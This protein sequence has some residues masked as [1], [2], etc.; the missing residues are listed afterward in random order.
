MSTTLSFLGVAGY[1]IAGPDHRILIDPC[2]TAN[3]AAPVGPDDLETPDVILVSHAA[4][5]HLGDTAAIARRTGAPVVCGAIHGSQDWRLG[6]FHPVSIAFGEPFD[7]LCAPVRVETL[8]GFDDA[9]VEEAAAVVE[10]S[11][12]RDLVRQRVLE[13][14]FGLREELCLV[15][16]L[17]GLEVIESATEGFIR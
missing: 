14:V 6:N 9:S 13:R 3:P 1:D 4:F 8:D 2:L 10:H 16:E 12:I 5:D 17:R 7:V 15:D 11:P